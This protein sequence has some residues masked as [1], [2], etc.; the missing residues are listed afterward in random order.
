M[1]EEQEKQKYTDIHQRMD[2]T[3]RTA[4]PFADHCAK[5]MVPK[6]NILDVGCGRGQTVMALRRLGFDAYGCDITLTGIQPDTP[7][8]YFY[9]G[10]AWNLPFEN[11]SF[12]YV[13]STD[14]LE[15]IYPIMV[16]ET[17]H[18]FIRVA[19]IGL[20][21]NIALFDCDPSIYFGHDVHVC[22]E[23]LDWWRERFTNILVI[24]NEPL[25]VNITG[26]TRTDN[27]VSW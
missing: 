15:H 20:I 1:T 9:E 17:I 8:E 2:Y 5:Q 13:I 24:R 27:F 12:D 14:V 19:R 10:A 22:V 26:R 3:S 16:D 25:I 21:H 11:K 4:V 23:T 6:S 7:R 18:E